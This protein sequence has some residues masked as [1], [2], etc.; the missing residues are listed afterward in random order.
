VYSMLP[1]LI[2]Y[3][4]GPVGAMDTPRWRVADSLIPVKPAVQT[5]SA[6]VDQDGGRSPADPA[7]EVVEDRLGQADSVADVLVEAP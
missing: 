4:G 6:A 1:T 7:L 3:S 2:G 5:A